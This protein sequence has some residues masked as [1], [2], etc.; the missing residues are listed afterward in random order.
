[1]W[2]ATFNLFGD[3]VWVGDFPT[4]EM[5][6]EYC[7]QSANFEYYENG[8]SGLIYTIWYDGHLYQ[9]ISF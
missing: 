7:R 3:E 2:R 5:A 6:V 8:V 1:M 4:Y 9:E